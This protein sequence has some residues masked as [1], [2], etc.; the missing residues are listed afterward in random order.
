MGANVGQ[1]AAELRALGYQGRIVSC[2]PLSAEYQQLARKAAGDST[3]ATLNCALGD[4]DG[5]R[6]INVAGNSKSSSLLDMLPA[7]RGR[8][9]FG[10]PAHRVR[11]GG[12]PGFD[13]STSTAAPG[14]RCS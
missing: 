4:I 14:T 5:V 7:R 11:D 10:L 9:T 6:D 12:P 13:L 8:P 3:W 1:Y 2:E